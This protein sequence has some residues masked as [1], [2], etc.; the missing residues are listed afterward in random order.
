M[1]F[2][3]K[4]RLFEPGR[5]KFFFTVGHIF[6]AKNTKLEHLLRRQLGLKFRVKILALGLSKLVFITALHL[7]IN[8]NDFFYSAGHIDIILPWPGKGA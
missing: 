8:S 3:I 7:V 2:R 5:W 1:E 4:F 6:A